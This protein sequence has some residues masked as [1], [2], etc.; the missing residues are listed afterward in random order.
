MDFSGRNNQ[1]QQIPSSYNQNMA[2]NYG[3]NP[4]PPALT[5]NW[6]QG[7]EGAKAYSVLPNQEVMLM[8]S[9]TNVL[10]T[11]KADMQGRIINFEIYD[12]V[13]REET[14]TPNLSEYA[15]LSDL[16][17]IVNDIVEKKLDELTGGKR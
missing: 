8:D 15:K 1:F 7:L 11:K 13:K 14:A 10:Y 9:E 5:I 12:L 2:M 4:Q 17:K 6:V 3:Y 16:D